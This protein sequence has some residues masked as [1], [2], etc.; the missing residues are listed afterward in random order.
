[1][2]QE[3][4]SQRSKELILKAGLELFSKQGYR[5]TSM[6]EISQQA[7]ISI[8]RVYHHYKKKLDIF[9]SLL[10]LYWNRLEDP[11]LKLNK[12]SQAARFPKTSTKL[13]MP[14]RKLSARTKI[15]SC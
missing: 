4:K 12:L 9:T 14:L 11:E 2:K 3:L 7:G 15:T 6:K 1:M 10:D 8:G 13:P 5:A